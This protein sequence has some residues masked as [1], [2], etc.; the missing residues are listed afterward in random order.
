MPL[1]KGR[2]KKAIAKNTK[3]EIDAGKSPDQAYAIAN[4]VAGTSKKKPKA[5]KKK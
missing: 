2:S 1:A 5:K 4:A 3:T